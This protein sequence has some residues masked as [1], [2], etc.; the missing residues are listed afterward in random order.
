MRGSKLI[1]M[2]QGVMV[3][4]ESVLDQILS[5]KNLSTAYQRVYQNQEMA[6][7]DKMTVFVLKG[8]LRK[9][10]NTS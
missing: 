6:G 10:H 1:S 3:M 2:L 7:V 4:R 8:Y 5:G 9:N